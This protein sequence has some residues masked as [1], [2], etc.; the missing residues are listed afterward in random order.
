ML[1]KDFRE[2]IALLNSAGVEYLI[3]GGYALA[4]HG[5]PRYTGDLDVWIRATE[6]NIGKLMEVL[7]RFGFGGLGLTR[8][9]FEQ[10][11]TVVQLGYPPNRIDLLTAIDG[12]EFDDCLARKLVVKVAGVDLPVIGLEDFRANKRAA[13]RAQDLADLDSLEGPKTP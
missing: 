9:D 1:D 2:F 12:V 3:V 13:G 8:K 7:D 5:H 6:I 11:G 4:A 10:P